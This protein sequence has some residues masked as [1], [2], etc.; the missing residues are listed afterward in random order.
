LLVYAAVITGLLEGL[1]EY[2]SFLS[3]IGEAIR[4]LFPSDIVT[5]SMI[6]VAKFLGDH[7]AIGA[8]II[9]ISIIWTTYSSKI[10]DI[11]SDANHNN[12]PLLARTSFRVV[13]S[14]LQ[15]FTFNMLS[16]DRISSIVRSNAEAALVAVDMLALALLAKNLGL[17]PSFI[18]ISLF[19]VIV[20]FSVSLICFGVGIYT[21]SAGQADQSKPIAIQRDGS[22]WVN[23][24]AADRTWWMISLRL[25]EPWLIFYFSLE[26]ISFLIFDSQNHSLGFLFGASLMLYPLVRQ[27]GINSIADAIFKTQ[28]HYSTTRDV[29]N[30]PED[31]F[32]GWSDVGDIFLALLRL[33][34]IISMI[35]AAILV[36]WIVVKPF[37]VS[38]SLDSIITLIVG[39][40]GLCSLPAIF[41][42]RWWLGK[43]ASVFDWL[44]ENKNAFEFTAVAI[45][46]AAIA[47]MF[48]EISIAVNQTSFQVIDDVC[49]IYNLGIRENHA[50][51]AQVV[52]FL[53]CAL[54]WS[55]LVAKL[56]TGDSSVGETPVR[57]IDYAHASRWTVVA[58][59]LTIMI[60]SVVVV[61]LVNSWIIKGY[62]KFESDRPVACS[63]TD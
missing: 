59:P 50:H 52:V 57:W 18:E 25:L 53:T 41:L 36:V 62:E 12:L 55:L 48:T 37:S 54:F 1:E 35:Y 58:R 15:L 20:L 23:A 8:G 9:G 2:F 51:A 29:N 34:L 19:S 17:M 61:Y 30:E 60:L 7:A 4:G 45:L 21:M 10:V 3:D 46:I 14:L 40:A 28:R 32:L 39:V 49:K 6:E 42:S 31:P 26:L 22:T 33:I 63:S 13:M 43:I 5:E 44:G 24:S 38:P 56:G 11:P 16:R 47:P 27:H